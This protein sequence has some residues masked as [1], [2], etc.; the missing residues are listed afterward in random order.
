MGMSVKAGSGMVL[1]RRSGG[2]WGGYSAR[3]WG[4]QGMFFAVQRYSVR[5]PI[6]LIVTDG[7]LDV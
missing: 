5:Y 4:W 2:G 3:R 6:L 7:G 1:V